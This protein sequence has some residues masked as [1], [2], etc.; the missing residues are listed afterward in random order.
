M[1]KL[2]RLFGTL[3]L[4]FSILLARAD[5]GMWLPL[6]LKNYN[7]ETMKNMGCKLTA[8]Q[9]YSLNNNSLKDAIVQL[10]GFCTAEI[11]SKQGLLFTNHHCAYDAIA[12]VSSTTNNYLEDGFWA[13]SK[14]QEKPIDGLTVSF[15]VRMEDVTQAIINH[16]ADATGQAASPL[17]LDDSGLEL[18]YAEAVGHI[19]EQAE[20]DGKYQVQVKEMFN[21]N[22]LYLFV[23]EVYTDIRLVG[24]PPEA[25]GKFGGDVDNWMWPRHTG[26]FSLLRIY[27]DK[28]NQPADFNENNVPFKPKHHL[29]ISIKGINEGD[30][31]M[32]MGFPGSTERYLTSY[33]VNENLTT[34]NPLLIKLMGKRLEIL[35]AQMDADKAVRLQLASSYASLHNSYKYYKGQNNTLKQNNFITTLK[36]EE[37]RFQTWANRSENL[38]EFGFVLSGIERTIETGRQ[39]QKIST[40]VNLAA[41]ASDFMISAFRYSSLERYLE[42]KDPESVMN[43][44]QEFDDRSASYFENTHTETDKILM[45]EM[46]AVLVRDLSPNELP[47]IF[48]KDLYLKAKGKTVE[49]KCMNMVNTIFSKSMM[50][51]EKNRNK[52]FAKP[53]L[54]KLQNDPGFQ[55][56]NSIVNWFRGNNSARYSYE[57]D[58]GKY[59]KAYMKGL[60]QMNQSKKFYP[61]ANFTLRLT[62]GQVQP[63]STRDGKP[64]KWQTFA[65]QILDKEDPNSEEFTVPAKLK[66]LIKNKEF[67]RYGE[68]GKLPVCFINNTD[69]TG[70]NSGSPVIDANGN[71]VG[72]AFDGN[73]ESMASDLV[74]EPDYV[75][76]ISVDVRYVLFIIDQ[77]AGAQNIIAE[78]DI[79]Q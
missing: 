72:I 39:S 64:Y 11:V 9:I 56:A 20:E 60:M 62:Y 45:A 42:N 59:K 55:V 31:Q 58:M 15:L 23:Y 27:A 67:G 10:G 53:K 38:D 73:W 48:S 25:V 76:T 2:T 6:L 70:G 26:D 1:N 3:V 46:L 29:P 16:M 49:E 12:S 41:F 34:S 8:D 40:Y 54:K 7:Y 35:K 63:Y 33:E 71:L 18:E 21:G 68:N 17:L 61:D 13:Y 28:N 57:E 4:L 37:E 50:T 14:D 79:K 43:R 22:A 75:R 69:I 77:Y 74:Y 30:F 78:L 36:K 65:S 44:K 24:A 47:D 66:E 5:E 51:N 32:I 19:E 52:F